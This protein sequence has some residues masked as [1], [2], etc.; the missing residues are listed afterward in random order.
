M[1]PEQALRH[2]WVIE[3][4]P[5]TVLYHHCKMYDIDPSEIP[6]HLLKG[7]GLETERV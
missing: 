4:L 1:T 2:I 6:A 7:T 5:K 3:G